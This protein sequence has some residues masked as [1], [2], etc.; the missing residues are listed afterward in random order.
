MAKKEE[1][2]Q[3]PI[4]DMNPRQQRLQR[5]RWRK[6][7]RSYYQRKKQKERT[8][9]M[10]IENTPPT[11]PSILY[12]SNIGI[13]ENNIREPS[14]LETPLLNSNSASP[15]LGTSRTL[16]ES[17]IIE[18]NHLSEPDANTSTVASP[19]GHQPIS[20]FTITWNYSESG[21]GKGAPDGVGAIMKRTADRA[22]Y[23]GQDIK[24]LD[25][26]INIIDQNLKKVKL[27]IVSDYDVAEKDLLFPQK[28]KSFPGCMK[29]HQLV[30]NLDTPT[31]AVRKLSCTDKT[32]LYHAIR[33][34]H[35]KH[36]EFYY[37]EECQKNMTVTP[38]ASSSRVLAE[39][40]QSF[41]APLN[42]SS[43]ESII[44]K[45]D[46]KKTQNKRNEI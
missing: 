39:I 31:I 46:E 5:K 7:Y 2:K 10:L 18:G 12:N 6:N 1:K 26:F 33:C 16:K 32:C 37:L 36:L 9:T 45:T 41:W 42:E 13:Q 4:N 21:H 29:M 19:S 35:M 25:D 8:A 22:V 3:L 15:I 34:K 43:D 44:A 28:V 30:W 14:P 11:S 24:N 17:G 38:L 20:S 23:Q 27:R 40:S